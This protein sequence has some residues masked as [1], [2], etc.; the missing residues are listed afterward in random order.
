MSSNGQQRS[1]KLT[2][3]SSGQVMSF[4]DIKRAH[5]MAADEARQLAN[6]LA[7]DLAEEFSIEYGWEDDVLYFERTG[8]H[9][10]INV[11]KNHIHIQAQ[12]GFLLAFLKPRI[13]EEIESVLGDHFTR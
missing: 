6:D 1:I 8:V 7:M 5:S 10:Q 4:I 11:D 3:P 9:G 2:L 12:L 13:E